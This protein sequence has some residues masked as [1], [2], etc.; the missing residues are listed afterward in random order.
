MRFVRSSR[1]WR[2]PVPS[3]LGLLDVRATVSEVP[4][5]PPCAVAEPAWGAAAGPAVL[6][7]AAGVE[8][9]VLA[10]D[11]QRIMPVPDS[12]A[13]R[14]GRA[15]LSPAGRGP[16]AA[17]GPGEGEEGPR[18]KAKRLMERGALAGAPERRSRCSQCLS[19][20]G[21]CVASGRPFVSGPAGLP[22]CRTCARGSHTPGAASWT[23][24]TR[25]R[26][27]AATGLPGAWFGSHHRVTRRPCC[28]APALARSLDQERSPT[29]A[30]P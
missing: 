27:T 23:P 2:R 6:R 15:S 30:V 19:A 3:V 17:G 11:C 16:E 9:S 1:S 26:R 25:A 28:R 8:A 5:E 7:R 4:A 14:G 20:E 10:P 24:L 13:G 21:G 12:R 18:S 29:R 22:R